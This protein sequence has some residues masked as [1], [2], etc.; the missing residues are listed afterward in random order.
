[1]VHTLLMLIGLLLMKA[2]VVFCSCSAEYGPIDV[3]GHLDVDS[4]NATI[5]DS[6][7]QGCELLKSVFIPKYIT[8][9]DTKAFKSCSSLTSVI[10]ELESQ[11]D[12]I[13]ISAF[14]SSGLLKA[15]LAINLWISLSSKNALRRFSSSDILDRSLISCCE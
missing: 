14:S 9:I 6:A 15:R 1:M 2:S 7:F 4:S 12:Y 5:S 11:L 3:N 10:F 8:I 13:G